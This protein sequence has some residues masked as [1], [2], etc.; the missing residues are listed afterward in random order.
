VFL[1]LNSYIEMFLAMGKVLW[2]TYSDIPTDLV[3]NMDELGNDTI[4]HRKNAQKSK[5]Q[6][7]IKSMRCTFMSKQ[8]EIAE[9]YGI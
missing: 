1:K 8:R 5:I 9:C 3:F 4:K 2:S 6:A 7:L